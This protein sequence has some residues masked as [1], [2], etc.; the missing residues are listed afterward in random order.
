MRNSRPKREVQK[1]IITQR[2]FKTRGGHTVGG[3]R[4]LLEQYGSLC[5]IV[6]R[7]DSIVY[8]LGDK[9]LLPVEYY[10]AGQLGSDDGNPCVENVIITLKETA[11]KK[12]VGRLT[13]LVAYMYQRMLAY[14]RVTAVTSDTKIVY[15]DEEGYELEFKTAVAELVVYH[16]YPNAHPKFRHL[17]INL[18]YVYTTKAEEGSDD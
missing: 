14:G 12:T 1:K 5:S 13:R 3:F 4:E 18:D 11:N 2:K 15:C 6:A 17:T 8:K 9:I 10:T 7:R 16:D